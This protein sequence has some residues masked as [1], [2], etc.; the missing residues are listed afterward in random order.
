MDPMD[1]GWMLHNTLQEQNARLQAQIGELRSQNE[2]LYSQ[3][4]ELQEQN[5]E[6]HEGNE[7][8]CWQNDKLK[9]EIGETHSKVEDWYFRNRELASELLIECEA[10]VA[11]RSEVRQYSSELNSFSEAN[12]CIEE[13]D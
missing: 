7:W 11:L 5:A 12:A 1:D 10:C 6:M 4:C 2:W 8:L 13:L 3:N 9:A